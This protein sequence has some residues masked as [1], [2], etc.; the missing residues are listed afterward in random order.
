MALA[1]RVVFYERFKLVMNSDADRVAKTAQLPF[2]GWVARL[3]EQGLCSLECREALTSPKPAFVP[4]RADEIRLPE[5]WHAEGPGLARAL[6][7]ALQECLPD[8]VLRDAHQALIDT[9]HDLAMFVTM[10]EPVSYTH[11]TLPTIYSV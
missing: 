4:L 2:D 3:A 1:S 7:D 6:A 11:L 5:A 10:L 8:G 9:L